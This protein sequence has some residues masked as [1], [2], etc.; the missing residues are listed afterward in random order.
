[1]NKKFMDVL[2]HPV[3]CKLFNDKILK[4]MN[5]IPVTKTLEKRIWNTSPQKQS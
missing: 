3:I 2:T 1:M 5:Q 4:I